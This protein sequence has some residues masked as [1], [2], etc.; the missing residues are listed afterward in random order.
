MKNK[1][2][3]IL[4]LAVAGIGLALVSG[5]IVQGP[6]PPPPPPPPGVVTTEPPPSPDTT[7]VVPDD[8]TWDGYEYVGLV[9]DQYYYLGPGSVWIVCDPVRLQRFHVWV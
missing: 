6:P 5:C 2:T 4:S 3:R 7:Y 9:G 1:S 8:Y